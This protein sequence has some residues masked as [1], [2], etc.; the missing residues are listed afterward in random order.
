MGKDELQHP[1][2]VLFQRGCHGIAVKL[3]YCIV[4]DHDCGL[5]LGLL[6]HQCAALCQKPV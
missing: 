5:C 4:C 1:K 6:P 3:I 2:A